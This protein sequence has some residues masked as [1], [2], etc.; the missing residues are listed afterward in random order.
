[1]AKNVFMR[2]ADDVGT[3]SA[4]SIAF[5]H[6]KGGTGKTTSCLNIAGWLVRMKKKALVVDL[7]PQGNATA[8]MGIDRKTLEGSIYDVFFGQ[9]NIEEIIIETDS[10]IRLAPSSIDLLAAETHMAGQINNT[11]LLKESLIDI[12]KH[13]DYILIDVPPGSTLLMI[14]GIVASENIIIPLDSGVFAYETLDTLK[15][16]LIDLRDELGIEVNVMMML[17]KRYAGIN[18]IFG[19]PTREMKKALKEFL[20]ENNIPSVNLFTIPF[21]IN[22]YK[23]QMRGMPISHYAPR[24]DVGRVYKGI[25]KEIINTD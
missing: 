12:E 19:N 22:I 24:S 21:S 14:N 4:K 13:F 25:A 1:M 23:A 9:H 7:D 20:V 8:G 16:L 2:G 3:R 18:T 11:T 5:V 15:T 17:L 6:H 10:G